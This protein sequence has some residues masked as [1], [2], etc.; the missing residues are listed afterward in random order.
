ML[1]TTGPGKRISSQEG[2]HDTIAHKKIKNLYFGG[3]LGLVKE[4]PRMIICGSTVCA[5]A[6]GKGR[7][8][9]AGI[10]NECLS[11]DSDINI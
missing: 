1:S 10:D 4:W 2:G 3:G 6:A 7:L 8:G 5:C 9:T 11:L